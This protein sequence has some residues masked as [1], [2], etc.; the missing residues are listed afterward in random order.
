MPEFSLQTHAVSRVILSTIMDQA[1]W[2]VLSAVMVVVVF[3]GL[4]LAD[5]TCR[6]SPKPRLSFD[7]CLMLACSVSILFGLAKEAAESQ[8]DDWFWCQS[9]CRF[10]WMD[11]FFN[12]DGALGGVLLV[13][14]GHLLQQ[15]SCQTTRECDAT[16][17]PTV[18]EEELDQVCGKAGPIP[19]QITVS[20]ESSC[21]TAESDQ[22]VPRRAP[23]EV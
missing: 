9:K 11:V 16:E 17:A 19:S 21:S 8:R 14:G 3:G 6:H 18:V 22:D 7:H 10:A 1:V 15:Q 5:G 4:R 12:V 20:S 23:E 2:C 13:I